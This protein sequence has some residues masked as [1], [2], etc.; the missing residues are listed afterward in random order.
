MI[1][2][3]ITTKA[4]VAIIESQSLHPF[5]IM[6]KNWQTTS[7]T[8]GLESTILPQS[9]LDDLNE[10]EN[11]E[12][13]IISSGLIDIPDNRKNTIQAFLQA[14]KNVYLQSEYLLSNP[15]NQTFEYLVEQL[16]G[17]FKWNGERAGSLAPMKVESD[18]FKA[19]NDID[20]LSY[21]WF[22]THGTGDASI[23]PIISHQ[24]LDYGF[25]FCPPSIGVGKLVTTSDQDWV[26]TLTSLDMMKNVLN[27]LANEQSLQAL[28][29]LSIDADNLN[30]CMG[31]IVNYTASVDT[32]L[33]GI[34]YQ[35]LVNGQPI[36]G[37][38]NN[39]FSSIGLTEGDYVECQLFLSSDCGTFETKSNSIVYDIIEPTSAPN[40]LLMADKLEACVNETF[41]ISA[42][43]SETDQVANIRY[44]WIIDGNLTGMSNDSVLILNNRTANTTVS[45]QLFYDDICNADMQIN[46]SQIELKLIPLV[47]PTITVMANQNNVC[48]GEP[49][50]FM[51]TGTNWGATPILDWYVDGQLVLKNAIQLTADFLKN[52]QTVSCRLSSSLPCLSVDQIESDPLH[53]AILDPVMPMVGIEL[54]RPN[55]CEGTSVTVSALGNNLG[56]DP[57]YQWFINGELQESDEPI[58]MIPTVNNGTSISLIV[59]ANGE[60]LL[61]ETVK[62]N[63]LVIN[64]NQPTIT[65]LEQVAEYCGQQNGILEIE[66]E[67]GTAP[68]NYQWMDFS[69]EPLRTDLKAGAYEVTVTDKF[70]CSSNVVLDVE[71]VAGPKITQLITGEVDC[72]NLNGW[73]SV[74]VKNGTG[75]LDYNWYNNDGLQLSL[76]ETANNLIPGQYFVSVKDENGCTAKDTVV[77]AAKDQTDF[78]IEA[79]TLINLGQSAIIK[80]NSN[81]N[82]EYTINAQDQIICE[83]CPST[84]VKPLVATTYTITAV[85]EYGCQ[86]TKTIDINV[87]VDR[88]V[89][90]PNA[91]SPN[92]DG[93]NDYFTIYSGEQVSQITTLRI[94]D[95]W[96]SVIFEKHKIQPGDETAGWNGTVNGQ[97]L[98]LGT[99]IFSAQIAYIDGH[100]ETMTGDIN[101]I[102]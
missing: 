73:A 98:P 101:L 27:Y 41:K 90:A 65:V 49:I 51:A 21:Y 7:S 75:K 20:E 37:A 32:L 57:T 59:K 15:G 22:G 56:V 39:R 19:P 72:D 26:R 36:A 64:T 89:Y 11:Y 52:G 31:T 95:R 79:P 66:A 6:D 25:I 8:M 84:E 1:A 67:S 23:Q 71:A 45:L 94:F 18:Y 34:A 55:I 42:I 93:R 74:E 83:D 46:S 33:P 28:P 100:T 44:N 14:G 5:H 50:T 61:R 76:S 85:N 35:W 3:S 12:V 38:T 86:M 30:P 77:L 16:G 87:A 80:L 69:T 54:D 62:A 102:R 60:C 92:G 78:E 24:N 9:T 99:Y 10:L 13:L 81:S 4:Q 29:T 70:G 43:L 53:I 47:T 97:V 17:Q 91:F 48:P 96:G 82:N 2:M 88:D 68:Y 63:D 40:I 58:L